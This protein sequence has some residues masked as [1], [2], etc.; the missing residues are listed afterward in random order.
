MAL[1]N[2]R[3]FIQRGAFAAAALC[4]DRIKAIADVSQPSEAS[5]QDLNSLDPAAIRRLGSQISGLII[6]PES[7]EY[8]SARMV[9][10]RAFDRRPALIVRCAE[11]SDVARTLDF[12]QKQNLPLAVRGG[13]HNRAGFGVCDGGA[14][15]DLSRMNR[16][17]VDPRKSVARA[18]GGALVRDLDQATQRYGLATTSGGCP[19]V[20]IAGLTLGGGEGFLM[21]KYGAACD[22][23]VSAQ[24]VTVDGRQVEASQTSNP[25]L[26]WAIRGGGGNFGVATALEYQLHPVTSVLAGTLIYPPGQLP[27]LLHTFAN[28]VAAAPDELNVVGQVLPSEKGPGFLVLFFYSGGSSQGRDILRN[29]QAPKPQEDTVRDTSYLET[30]RTINPYASVAHFQTDVVV[31]ELSPSVIQL[32]ATAASDAPLN[33]RVFIVPFYGAVTRVGVSDTAFALRQP[34]YELDIM[35]RW[36]T[37]AEREA[38]V[39][40]VKALHAKLQPFA[41]GLYVNQ[42]GET[43]D[44]LVRAGYGPNYVRLAEIKKKYDPG[45]LLRL[46]Q[47]IKPA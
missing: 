11:A 26:F 39:Q 12:V 41:R 35:G 43:S 22:N 47:N 46:N 8:E 24:L 6:T 27:A 40:W 20:G 19:T 31:P 16:V 10:N 33:T 45:N 13:G 17:D 25:D 3:Q 32:I 15:I 30:Q 1:T 29:W 21:S 2:R 38:A 18:E 42:L 28:L 4:A 36:N 34:G 23:L 5:E 44:D 7:T 14:V 37:P 9:F